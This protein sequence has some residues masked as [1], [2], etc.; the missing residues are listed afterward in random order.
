[1]LNDSGQ[2]LVEGAVI[3]REYSCDLRFSAGHR[4][5]PLHQYQLPDGRNFFEYVQEGMAASGREVVF[6][7]LQD[8]AGKVVPESLW[9]ES[10]CARRKT[11]FG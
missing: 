5:L 9:S 8:S 6:L 11:P 10:E 1:M 7:A 3:K 2:K 4:P